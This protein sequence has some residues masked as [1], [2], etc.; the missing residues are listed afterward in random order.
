M[1][2]ETVRGGK[3]RVGRVWD[4]VLYSLIAIV[5]V[6]AS[7]AW[8]IYSWK[9][10]LDPKLLMRWVAFAAETSLVFGYGAAVWWR[11]RARPRFWI[12]MGAFFAA[13]LIGGILIVAQLSQVPLLLIGL[14]AAA[15]LAFLFEYLHRFVGSPRG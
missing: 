1:K 5:L 12:F 11:F 6:G 7:W 3:R 4:A 10:G 13:H 9:A 15:E 14:I 8:G 2:R